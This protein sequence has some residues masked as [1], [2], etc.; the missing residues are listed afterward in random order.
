MTTSSFSLSFSYSPILYYIQPAFLSQ[1]LV[2][3]PPP[4][5]FPRF[6]SSSRVVPVISL[7]FLLF[8]LPFL[9]PFLFSSFPSITIPRSTNRFVIVSPSYKSQRV[10]TFSSSLLFLRR[11]LVER[12]TD[13][14]HN[15]HPP[16]PSNFPPSALLW[17]SRRVRATNFYGRCFIREF[18]AAG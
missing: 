3:L 15:P 11:L 1:T 18:A 9:T 14:S 16:R 10:T 8:S 5:F 7:Y 6:V 17:N 4:L 2:L 13:V 12:G